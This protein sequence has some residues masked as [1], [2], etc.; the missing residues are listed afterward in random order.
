VNIVAQLQNRYRQTEDP[1]R[2]ER[3]LEL[4][5]V[6]VTLLFLLLVVFS[7]LRLSMLAEPEARPPAPESLVVA[8]A[9]ITGAVTGEMRNEINAR[10]VFFPSRRPLSAAPPP[11]V[12]DKTTANKS[13]LDKVQLL[14]VFGGG[15]TAGVIL[16]VEGKKQR[17][18]VGEAV[19]GWKLKTVD[20]NEAQFS[21]GGK[22]E[23]LVLQYSGAK[24]AGNGGK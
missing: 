1:L 21:S 10:P 8:D 17:L 5:A 24:A 4:A 15:E 11:P 13:E 3:Y 12:V 14:G 6:V 7:G 23:T 9:M 22:L 19:K 18:S 16:L 2:S 20:L